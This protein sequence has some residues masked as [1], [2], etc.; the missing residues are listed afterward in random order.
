MRMS[1]R[2][3]AVAAAI[4]TAGRAAAQTPDAVYDSLLARFRGGDDVQGL[5]TKH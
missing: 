5:S 2:A 4:C 1:L 3:L